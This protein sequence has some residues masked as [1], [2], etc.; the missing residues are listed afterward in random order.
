LIAFYNFLF[1]YVLVD[2]AMPSKRNA[3]DPADCKVPLLAFTLKA[4]A[5]KAP[6]REAKADCKA[7]LLAFTLKAPAPKAPKREAQAGV[8][9]EQKDAEVIE[10]FAGLEGGVAVLKTF[11]WGTLAACTDVET[12]NVTSVS[13]VVEHKGAEVVEQLAG[14][15]SCTSTVATAADTDTKEPAVAIDTK[16][17]LRLHCC[18]HPWAFTTNIKD[19]LEILKLHQGEERTDAAA[20]LFRVANYYFSVSDNGRGAAFFHGG[21]KWIRGEAVTKTIRSRIFFFCLSCKFF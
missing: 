12:G 9:V 15:T 7:R 19:V 8:V 11:G 16:E 2:V 4:P 10:Q 18:Y 5:P 14:V 6:K 21:F 1:L 13:I 20:H 3:P 17:P